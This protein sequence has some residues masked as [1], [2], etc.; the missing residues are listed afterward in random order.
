MNTILHK[1]QA[2]LGARATDIIP[3]NDSVSIEYATETRIPITIY[4]DPENPEGI[5]LL[6]PMIQKV[7]MKVDLSEC[8]SVH[9]KRKDRR[10][11]TEVLKESI[12]SM[13]NN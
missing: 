3:A 4:Q 12:E 10:S 1:V 8:I 6:S 7:P 2:A 13:V 9:E 5:V 11:I